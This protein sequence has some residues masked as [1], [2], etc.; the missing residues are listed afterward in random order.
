MSAPRSTAQKQACDESCTV[1]CGRCKGKPLY[2]LKRR[3]RRALWY[4][5]DAHGGVPF[6]EKDRWQQGYDEAKR[7][8]LAV[9]DGT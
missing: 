9:L 4:G 6:A 5:R 2:D 7:Q 1:D 8:V 3:I